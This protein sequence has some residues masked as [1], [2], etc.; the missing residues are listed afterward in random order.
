MR[1][2]QTGSPAAASQASGRSHQRTCCKGAA[3]ICICCWLIL[4]EGKQHIVLCAAVLHT[5]ERAVMLCLR[6]VYG[7]L[8]CMVPCLHLDCAHDRSG[9]LLYLGTEEVP[10]SQHGESRRASGSDNDS[11]AALHQSRRSSAAVGALAA[12]VQLQSE[13]PQ[14]ADTAVQKDADVLPHSVG[15]ADRGVTATDAAA[16]AV[17]PVTDAEPVQLRLRALLQTSEAAMA[18]AD[19]DAVALHDAAS[20]VA[21][22]QLPSMASTREVL[23]AAL[24]HRELLP[25]DGADDT[26]DTLQRR[27]VRRPSTCAS[28]PDMSCAQHTVVSARN[29]GGTTCDRPRCPRSN[30]WE[31]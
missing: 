8:L 3:A 6:A 23:E 22:G 16:T 10:S 30:G 11:I 31:I 13:A 25:A 7:F 9:A 28:E 24:A 21:A 20:E 14:A 29:N 17:G 26:I 4:D 18:A 12:P 2:W 15:R 1:S 27:I 5:R 19:V